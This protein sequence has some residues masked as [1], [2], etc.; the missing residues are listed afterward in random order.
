MYDYKV[1]QRFSN[2]L[3]KDGK[4]TAADRI[5]NDT[6]NIL[7]MYGFK[8]P[9]QT[10]IE[11]IEIIKPKVELRSQKKSGQSVQIPTAMTS[12]RQEGMAMRMLKEAA[13]NRNVK[14]KAL[15]LPKS[16]TQGKV[17]KV[18]HGMPTA[19]SMEIRSVLNA[20]GQL[21]MVDRGVGSSEGSLALNRRDTLHRM[22]IAQRGARRG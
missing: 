15:V 10:R 4:R 21:S 14:S 5:I 8:E 9:Y 20:N 6:A 17:N 22:A 12:K 7:K 13:Q 16:S 18:Y 3:R 1:L 19:L 11:V 2:I